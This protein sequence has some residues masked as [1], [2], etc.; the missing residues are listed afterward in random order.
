[1]NYSRN[2]LFFLLISAVPEVIG[3]VVVLPL[4]EGCDLVLGRRLQ[5]GADVVRPEVLGG[6]ARVIV[7]RR[8]SEIV[9][10]RVVEEVRDPFTTA[11]SP[12]R[13]FRGDMLA[14]SIATC[15]PHCPG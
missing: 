12:M 15:I 3:D 6:L 8:I 9:Q 10:V 2:Q 13:S 14:L 4:V 1:M 11:P 5:R 7:V